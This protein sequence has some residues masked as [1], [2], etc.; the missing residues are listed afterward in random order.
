MSGMAEFAYAPPSF[1]P[2]VT[3]KERSANDRPDIF[4]RRYE[5][6]L[7]LSRGLTTVRQEDFVRWL[8]LGLRR[9]VAFNSLDVVLDRQSSVGERRFRPANRNPVQ[10]HRLDKISDRPGVSP[11]DSSQRHFRHLVV[12][13]Q[14]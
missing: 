12:N 13:R 3:S 8:T 14:D 1:C 2:E 4:M 11:D 6:L 7:D 9:V 10:Q 5:A